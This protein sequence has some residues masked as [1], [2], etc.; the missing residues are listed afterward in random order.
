[1]I[2]YLLFI[3]FIYYFYLLFIIYHLLFIIYYLLFIISIY[4]FKLFIIYH[5]L[6]IIYFYY[7]LFFEK[8]S[9][10][11]AHDLDPTT[12]HCVQTVN[13]SSVMKLRL[14]VFVGCR[15]RSPPGRALFSVKIFA[16]FLRCGRSTARTLDWSMTLPTIRPVSIAGHE[17]SKVL[18]CFR[19]CVARSRVNYQAH[20]SMFSR[21]S[22]HDQRAFFKQVFRTRLLIWLKFR[23]QTG[24]VVR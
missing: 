8:K 6:F 11:F 23:R 19:L 10:L 16:F 20:S 3:I 21:G 2:I 18:P 9:F 4:F 12:E 24:A 22:V 7:L 14:C 13:F 5:L 15:P 17:C 1:M